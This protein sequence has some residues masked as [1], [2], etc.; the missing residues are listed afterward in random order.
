MIR[1]SRYLS[2]FLS[3]LIVRN[4][5][6]VLFDADKVQRVP[7]ISIPKA[8]TTTTKIRENKNDKKIRKTKRITTMTHDSKVETSTTTTTTRDE[9]RTQGKELN[10]KDKNNMDKNKDK[11]CG[12]RRNPCPIEAVT[13][14]PSMSPTAVRTLVPSVQKTLP[15]TRSPQTITF[16]S[17]Q[18]TPP[19]TARPRNPT[20]S[21]TRTSQTWSSH[22]IVLS[23]SL[24]AYTNTTKEPSFRRRLNQ[25]LESRDDTVTTSGLVPITSLD[26]Y[27]GKVP[28]FV[29]EVLSFTYSHICDSK[30]NDPSSTNPPV[31]LV[32]L[33]TTTSTAEQSTPLRTIPRN[34]E[35][36]YDTHSNNNLEH[37]TNY[38]HY[39]YKDFCSIEQKIFDLTNTKFDPHQTVLIADDTYLHNDDTTVVVEDIH[40]QSKENDLQWLQW[41]FRLRLLQLSSSWNNQIAQFEKQ[42]QS[43]LLSNLTSTNDRVQITTTTVAAMSP[44]GTEVTTFIPLLN[45][46]FEETGQ[47]PLQQGNVTALVSTKSKKK[48]NYEPLDTSKMD[49]LQIVGIICFTTTIVAMAALLFS[50]ISRRNKRLSQQKQWTQINLLE[51]NDAGGTEIQHFLPSPTKLSSPQLL[52]WKK[53]KP[54]N[55]NKN[56]EKNAS[57]PLASQDHQCKMEKMN[58]EGGNDTS[59][60]SEEIS[61]DSIIVNPKQSSHNATT[62]RN[63]LPCW[64]SP[65]QSMQDQQSSVP[66]DEN[67]LSKPMS[68]KSSTKAKITKKKDYLKKKLAFY[69]KEKN[70]NDDI[71]YDMVD[72]D[73]SYIEEIFV[74]PKSQIHGDRDFDINKSIKNSYKL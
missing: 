46:H 49:A 72:D 61:E 50:S 5:Y 57:I 62:S 38:N 65:V 11:N 60:D 23:F 3:L 52:P 66:S 41:T 28:K 25:P 40:Y 7:V 58:D 31:V 47:H 13:E 44:L 34:S 17:R 19:P 63:T 18:P 16:F 69:T 43:H 12:D 74:S 9:R 45:Q 37:Y 24:L 67:F 21:P 14:T 56:D 39:Q 8:T 2:L 36:D 73:Q 70:K 27:G 53:S 59:V 6:S 10:Q 33:R 54:I 26:V 30:Q 51:L 22:E 29:K 35:W 48:T 68:P 1:S 32:P 55:N 15:Q 42:V 4:V 64:Q 71:K 20:A